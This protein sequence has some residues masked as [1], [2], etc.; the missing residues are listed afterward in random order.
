VKQFE[1][2]V[3]QVCKSSGLNQFRITQT[4]DEKAIQQ[5]KI[6]ELLKKKFNIQVNKS[7]YDVY[8]EFETMI[9]KP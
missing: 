4:G 5:T 8:P 3:K 9:D 7:K 6:D 1:D 2:R